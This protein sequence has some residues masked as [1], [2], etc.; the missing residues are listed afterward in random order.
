MVTS[1]VATDRIRST[2]APHQGSPPGRVLSLAIAFVVFLVALPSAAAPQVVGLGI[3]HGQVVEAD[4]ERPIAH[5]FI[6]ILDSNDRVR[7]RVTSDSLGYFT[8]RDLDPG[9][10]RIRVRS[11]GYAETTTPRWWLESFE[12]LTLVVRVLPEAVLLAP[13]EVVAQARSVSPVLTGF[14][15]RMNRVG[16]EF[17]TA[18]QIS[19]SNATRVSDLMLTIPGVRMVNSDEGLITTMERALGYCPAQIWIDGMLVTRA[20]P[21]PVDILVGPEHLVGVEVYKGLASVPPEFY[22]EGARCGVV[23]L[24]TQRGG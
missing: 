13:L 17:I 2:K 3:I 14:F 1:P 12:Q 4:V 20:G 6:D 10:F 23:A 11:I 7:K 5:A 15:T 19:K 9:S 16:G 18:E 24:W 21:V 8:V 22:N